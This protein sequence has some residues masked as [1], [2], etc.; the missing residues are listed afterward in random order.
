MTYEAES[1][2][3]EVEYGCQDQL[4]IGIFGFSHTVQQLI[5]QMGP[6]ITSVHRG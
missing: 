6:I 3:L 1:L 2:K 4:E 5:Q